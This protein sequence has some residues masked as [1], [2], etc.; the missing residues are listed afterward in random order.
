MENL[1]TI[2]QFAEAARVSPKALRLYA[3]N[4]LLAPARIDGDSGY[5]YYGLEQLHTA[6]LIG[7]LRVAGMSLREI[8]RVLA[9]PS[10]EALDAYEARLE[11]EL[12]E[13]RE[14]L[15]YVRRILEEAPMFE[16]KV[17]QVPAQRYAS[18]TANVRVPDLEPFILKTID[19]LSS[20]DVAGSPFTIFHGS[21][22]EESDGPV[23]VCV[24]RSD[25]DRELPEG[26]V[27]YTT[28]SGDQCDFPEILGAY[29]AVAR[30]AREQGR[31]FSSPP[32]EIYLSAPGESMRFEIAWPLQ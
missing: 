26:E 17:K 9:D 25:G 20:E 8:G 24:P 21:V 22:T 6:R 7:L 4:G 3:A 16:V 13:R 19:E 1:V 15:A 12:G 5:R 11:R 31:E 30:W 32:R 27:A 18:R 23:E 10:I 29:D 28:A 14:V 2:G